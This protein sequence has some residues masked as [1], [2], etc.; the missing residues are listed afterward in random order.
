MS[1]KDDIDY[2]VGSYRCEGS[3]E[4]FKFRICLEIS[5]TSFHHKNTEIEKKYT[6]RIEKVFHW[7]EKTLDEPQDQNDL[8]E[9]SSSI[10]GK[11]L[12]SHLKTKFN[13]HNG[14]TI[15]H[16]VMGHDNTLT[17]SFKKMGLM[18]NKDYKKNAYF[19]TKNV[20]DN[21]PSDI[22]KLQ[23]RLPN[24]NQ[25]MH[26]LLD[27]GN[28]GTDNKENNLVLASLYWNPNSHIMTI[29]PDFTTNNCSGY[30]LPI[31]TVKDSCFE[32]RFWIE[33]LSNESLELITDTVNFHLLKL[34]N[35]EFYIPETDTIE[36]F[37]EIT[38]ASG[39][40]Y[41]N[42]FIRYFIDL[43]SGWECASTNSLSGTTHTCRRNNNMT[44]IFSYLFNVTIIL[45]K[46]I[47]QPK[48]Q[49]INSAFI[50]FIIYSIDSWNKERVEGYASY[51]IPKFST[52]ISYKTNIKLEAWLPKSRNCVHNLQRYFIGGTVKLAEPNYTNVPTNFNEKL[53]SKFGMETE[54]RGSLNITLS[55][56]MQRCKSIENINNINTSDIVSAQALVKSVNNVMASF[57]RA[58]QRMLL[59]CQP[60]LSPS[61]N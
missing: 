37:A 50:T 25:I 3:V 23:N 13:Q 43:P 38:S 40:E 36:I 30:I 42:L 32:Y 10:E 41:D 26:V 6:K 33:N 4:H 16:E 20:I 12:D 19:F 53:L 17:E 1:N 60:I 61:H 48:D 29:F 7:M 57:K 5:R 35:Y 11:L 39:F 15:L 52:P 14:R 46:T 22:S 24:F 31:S 54:H 9:T 56:L 49:P 44:S 27:L 2:D 18:N 28:N 45:P 34:D 8:E 51:Q 55:N 21:L 47:D 59:A 58:R